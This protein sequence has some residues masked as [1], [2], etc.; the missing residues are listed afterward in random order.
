VP[1]LALRSVRSLAQHL[2]RFAGAFFFDSDARLVDRLAY[3]SKFLAEIRKW[4]QRRSRIF[5]SMSRF[6]ITV[7]Y[8]LFAL[9]AGV[10]TASVIYIYSA[11]R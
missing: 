3:P 8:A 2:P 6:E 11:Y 5:T 4:R 1:P 7:R 9:L 10:L